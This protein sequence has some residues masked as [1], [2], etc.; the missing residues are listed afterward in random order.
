MR[1]RLQALRQSR[2]QQQ[3][4]S[5]AQ[6]TS[7]D[8]N[9]TPPQPSPKTMQP[10]S[11]AMGS[12]YDDLPI[13][14]GDYDTV[15]REDGYLSKFEFACQQGPLSTVQSMISSQTPPPTSFYLHYGLVVAIFAGNIDI[16]RYLLSLGAPIVRQTPENI[17]HVPSTQQIPLFELLLQ[18]G[19]TVNTPSYYGAV[20]LPRVV[21]NLPL[22]RWFLAHGANP[23]LGEE[24]KFQ[25]RFGGSDTNSCAALETAAYDGN[26]DAVRLLLDA[27]AEIRNG[28]PLKSAA[29]ACPPGMDIHDGRVTPLSKD[30][31]RSRIPVMALLVE[32]GAD[33]NQEV[34][35]RF[36]VPRYPIVY[37]VMAGAVERVRW[38]LEQGADAEAKGRWGNA[39]TC[40]AHGSEE[41][42]DVIDEAVRA[43]KASEYHRSDSRENPIR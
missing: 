14:P 17:F 37:A 9:S 15:D 26:V 34:K 43:K 38:L 10:Q 31:D 39:L 1:S 22:L 28:Y 29:A 3:L 42:R 41:M 24:R 36:V 19:W 13:D 33:V 11:R 2:Q 4:R 16:A 25:D 20:L 30:F 6:N 7:G 8:S 35:S 12:A 40:A 23:N 32:H 21:D 5:S 27:G 18:Y